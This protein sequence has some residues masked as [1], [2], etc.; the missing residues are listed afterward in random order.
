[1]RD[2]SSTTA[3]RRSTPRS[4]GRSRP[5]AS[6][7][8]APHLA[9]LGGT[10]T[11]NASSARS[12]ASVWTTSSSSMNG[13]FVESFGPISRTTS[14]LARISRS[15]RMRRWNAPSNRRAASWCNLKSAVCTTA[16]NGK[17]PDRAWL[18]RARDRRWMWRS[19]CG[20]VPGHFQN[21][22][23]PPTSAMTHSSGRTSRPRRTD[24]AGKSPVASLW[25]WTGARWP[26]GSAPTPPRG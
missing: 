16:T 18:D 10:P 2:S 21:G 23:R 19:A 1:M 26:G 11:L 20:L 15:A 13:I 7:P 14:G 6:P 22:I 25:R 3:T 17:P 12:A 8:S 5:S 4:V 24:Y 9:R